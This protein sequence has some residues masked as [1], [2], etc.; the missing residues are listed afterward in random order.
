[1]NVLVERDEYRHRTVITAD[2]GQYDG[3]PLFP[4][5]RVSGMPLKVHPDREAVAAGLI[6]RHSIAGSLNL[7]R[8][9][10]P[11]VGSAL[12]R[13][14]AP[15]DL[16]VLSIDFEPSRIGTGDATLH[17]VAD[18]VNDDP[19]LVVR[20]NDVMFR[21]LKEGAGF[22]ATRHEYH[23]VSN[24]QLISDPKESPF[25]QVMPALGIAVLFAEDLFASKICLPR[26][27]HDVQPELSNAVR[28]LLD[29]VGLKL[30][31]G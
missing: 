23:V 10:S 12:R 2:P 13:F 31:T 5:I 28:T 16:H 4:A 21:V 19:A 27:N 3:R 22:L 8:G 1:M 17:V 15:E 11:Q 7:E 6:L 18:D 20:G 24:A 26:V 30:L 14:F 29:A 9:C 25:E